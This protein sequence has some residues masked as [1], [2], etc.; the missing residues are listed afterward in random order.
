VTR[1]ALQH[2]ALEV[3]DDFAVL[4]GVAVLREHVSRLEGY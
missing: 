1:D 3:V 4:D 2:V